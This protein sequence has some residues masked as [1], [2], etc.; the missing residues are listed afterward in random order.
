MLKVLALCG[1]VL[2]GFTRPAQAEWHF[3]PMAGLTMFGNTSLFDR[4]AATGLRHPHLGFGVSLLSDGILGAEVVTFWTPGFF[5]NGN[6]LVE[7][8]RTVTGMA[9]LVLT[10]PRR[11]TEYFVRPYVSGG[12]GLMHASVVDKRDLF[13]IEMNV[14]GFNIGGGAVG[15]LSNSTGLRFDFRYHSTLN[16]PEGAP[17]FGPAVHLRYVTAS[18]GVVFRR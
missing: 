4:E 17:T 9:N 13:P 18:I 6:E 1:V 8:S 7:T 15:F 14:A 5:E 3:T 2:L 11:W 16:R 12:F 10:T